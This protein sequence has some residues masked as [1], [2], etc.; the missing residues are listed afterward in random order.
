MEVGTAHCPVATNKT[1]CVPQSGVCES[2]FLLEQ[3][4]HTVQELHQRLQA[5]AFCSFLF[6]TILRR[7]HFVPQ[8]LNLLQL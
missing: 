2:W 3:L 7:K 4:L 1:F 8:G 6:A 5:I